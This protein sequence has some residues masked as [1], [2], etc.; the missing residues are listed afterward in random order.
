MKNIN[1]AVFF[2]KPELSTKAI[3]DIS[4]II[5]DICFWSLHYIMKF[6]CMQMATMIDFA[7]DTPRA[8]TH[9]YTIYILS[10]TYYVKVMYILVSIYTCY[11]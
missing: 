1:C 5:F 2:T 8:G 11:K 3:S 10:Y 4:F 7:T 9:M 6:G